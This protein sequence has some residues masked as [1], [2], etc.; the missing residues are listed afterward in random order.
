MTRRLLWALGTA[1]VLSCAGVTEPA[2]NT[3]TNTISLSLSAT[4]LTLAPG[5]SQQLD[6]TVGRRA[7]GVRLSLTGLP[8]GLSATFLPEVLPD[9]ETKSSLTLAA[10]S[11]AP[12]FDATLTLSA[13]TTADARTQATA[14][15]HVRVTYCPGYAIPSSCPPF[16]T[17]GANV[18]TGTVLERA[19]TG[20]TSLAGVS[21]W[22]WVEY[23][24]RNGYSAGRVESNDRGEYR[25]PN[26]PAAL[27]VL[28]T[29][30]T[31]YDQP[32]ASFTQ[33]TGPSSTANI[34]M[35]WQGNARADTNPHPPALAGGVYEV[36]AS[37]QKPVADARIYFEWGVSEMVVATTTTDALGRYSLCGLPATG[38]VTITKGGY[39]TATRPVSISGVIRMDVEMKRG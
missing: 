2:T 23:P 19:A 13:T 12:A 27:I 28:Q 18:L 30:R 20:T 31:G 36:T 14:S 11:D 32:C 38:A 35:V 33:L 22:A 39:I 3:N 37:G 16:P 7:G 29:F 9:G 10:A 17:G 5:T 8:A 4:S 6:V 24:N 15:L 21:V 1:A 25:F 26:L 34:E